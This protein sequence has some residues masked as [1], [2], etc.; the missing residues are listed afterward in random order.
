V[1]KGG[2]PQAKIIRSR[3][4]TWPSVD[5][6]VRARDQKWNDSHRFV[7]LLLI[8]RK[9]RDLSFLSIQACNCRCNRSRKATFISSLHKKQNYIRAIVRVAHEAQEII[10]EASRGNRKTDR[11]GKCNCARISCGL[12]GDAHEISQRHVM[13]ARTSREQSVTMNSIVAKTFHAVPV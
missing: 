10:D 13:R 5:G 11:A 2:F 12:S 6:A 3:D 8:G 7:I 9:I 1:L 4:G